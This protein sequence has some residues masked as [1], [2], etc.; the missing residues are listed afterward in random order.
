MDRA[1]ALAYIQEEYQEIAS[2]SGLD[3][4]ALLRTYGRAIDRSLRDLGVEE[5]AIVTATITIAN[6]I[7]AYYALLD[8]YAL[9][10]F[11]RVFS[12]RTDVSVSGALS[13]SQSQAFKQVSSLLGEAKARLLDLGL[14]PTEEFSMGRLS[15]DYIEP[16]AGSEF[17][18]SGSPGWGYY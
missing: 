4:D 6:D 8:Y 9:L 2:E 14:G 10:R 5:D 15:L 16:S 3:A 7:T 1:E 17:A 12:T 11:S 18:G 13:S